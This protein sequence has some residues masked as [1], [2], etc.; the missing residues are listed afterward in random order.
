MRYAYVSFIL[1]WY[2]SVQ[3][4]SLLLTA[5]VLFLTSSILLSAARCGRG[6]RAWS[7][8]TV[9][10][11]RADCGSPRTVA[12]TWASSWRRTWAPAVPVMPSGAPARASTSWTTSRA[13]RPVTLTWAAALIGWRWWLPITPRALIRRYTAF[14]RGH[15]LT[16]TR[17][18]RTSP[19][20]SRCWLRHWVRVKLRSE[21]ARSVGSIPGRVQ[22]FSGPWSDVRVKGQGM[23]VLK[24]RRCSSECRYPL[25]YCDE[26]FSRI[27]W[28]VFSK[29][30]HLHGCFTPHIFAQASI[31]DMVF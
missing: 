26:H 22:L 4:I 20:A 23:R 10:S 6:P 14:N 5:A 13:R 8:P 31:V 27:M 1:L 16:L 9:W 12:E 21:E 2:D 3:F 24:G 19:R 11:R 25:R 30:W 7:A 15:G 18:S 28:R 17:A 29:M